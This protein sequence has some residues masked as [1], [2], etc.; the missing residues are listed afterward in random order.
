MQVVVPGDAD[1]EHLRQLALVP[2]GGGPHIG[3]GGHFGRLLGQRHLEAHVGVPSVTDE[4]VEDAE[5]GVGL[6]LP[7]QPLAL[8]HAAEVVEHGE[9]LG[10]FAPEVAQHLQRPVGRHP[11]RGDA[12]LRGLLQELDVREPLAQLAQHRRLRRLAAAGRRGGHR[13]LARLIGPLRP[14]AARPLLRNV[15]PLHLRLVAHH[16]SSGG[17]SLSMA[18]TSSWRRSRIEMPLGFTT[19]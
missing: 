8:V 2:V 12:V 9:R 3:D 5:R 19:P 14:L 10:G 7:V 13:P 16:I 11:R 1:A 6:A 15:V 18:T 4:V 17:L